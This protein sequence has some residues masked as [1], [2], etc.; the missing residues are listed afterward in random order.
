MKVR[1]KPIVVDATPISLILRVG[2]PN[3][4][5]LLDWVQ[6]AIRDQK[7]RVYEDVVIVHTL[8]GNMRGTDGDYLM[9]G[10]RGEFYPIAGD[11]FQ[12]TY[13]VVDYE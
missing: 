4:D 8:E 6:D 1:K 2:R 12:E 5:Y 13:E 11:I 7:V 9:R 10:T 3:P